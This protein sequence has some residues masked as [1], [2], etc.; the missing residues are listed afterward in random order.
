MKCFHHTDR[1]AVATCQKCSK[2]LYHPFANHFESIL[3]KRCLLKNNKYKAKE[4]YLGLAVTAAIFFSSTFLGTFLKGRT[5]SF[6]FN[7]GW[8]IS[9]LLAFT[10]WG[11]IF[12]TDYFP[13]LLEGTGDTWLI[14]FFVKFIAA[15][16]IG[17]IVVVKFD[18][19]IANF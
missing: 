3:C 9:L 6:D 19:G 17:I 4:V 5:H 18:F 1:D 14:Y 16:F 8:L 11:W 13:S 15:Y 7:K 2:G 10:Y 12:L